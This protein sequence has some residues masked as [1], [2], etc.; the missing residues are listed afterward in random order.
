MVIAD[1]MAPVVDR[2]HPLD[3]RLNRAFAE[4]AQDRGFGPARIRS[5]QDS[6][7]VSQTGQ[8]P[9]SPGPPS[10]HQRA[11]QARRML[12]PKPPPG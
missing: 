8:W 6:L 2:A 9:T 4:Y 3:P 10:N 11:N 12:E 7:D 5:P 1:N